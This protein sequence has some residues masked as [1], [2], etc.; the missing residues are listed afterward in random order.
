MSSARTARLRLQTG[1][2]TRRPG[3]HALPSAASSHNPAQGQG[4]RGHR[5]WGVSFPAPPLPPTTA[6]HRPWLPAPG[7]WRGRYLLPLAPKAKVPLAMRLAVADGDEATLQIFTVAADPCVEEGSLRGERATRHGKAASRRWARGP[8][9]SQ[10]R[11]GGLSQGGG[12]R[13]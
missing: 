10:G 9:L 4:P 13:T 11:G 8:G 7:T 5:A 3:A 2:A 12:H 1:R 6:A